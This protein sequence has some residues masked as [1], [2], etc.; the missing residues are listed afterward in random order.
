MTNNVYVALLNPAITLVFAAAFVVLWSYQRQRRY[1]LLFSL[2]Y[3]AASLGFLAQYAD[4]PGL[5][6][7]TRLISVGLFTASTLLIGSAVLLIYRRR[8]PFIGFAAVTAVG[9]A[10]FGWFLFVEPD[11]AWRVLITNFTLGGITLLVAAELRAL[12]DKSRLDWLLFWLALASGL[13]FFVRTALI[14]YI[15]GI[16]VPD[17]VHQSVYWTTALLSHAV[18]S[19]A[20]ALALIGRT[21]QDVITGLTEE[22]QT[23]PLS[24][25]LNRRGFGEHAGKLLAQAQR[26]GL[27]VSLVICDLDHF[28]A[29][30]DSFGHAC[31]DRVIVAAS[32]FFEKAASANYVVGRIGG[33]EFAIILSGANMPAARLFAEGARAAFSA[34][35]VDGL[36][37]A[38]R[39]T[40]SFGVAEL[41]ENE[42]VSALLARADA[43]LYRAKNEGRDRVCVARPS[44]TR[45]AA[46][47]AEAA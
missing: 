11:L 42:D 15:H 17:G 40:A 22:S 46:G 8:P 1:L 35:A 29:V 37:Q 9:A 3:V 33:E 24:G 32:S 38:H 13:N 25:L 27:P 31:G 34:I 21:V 26:R 4:A 30:N 16:D 36:P 10:G 12:P 2:G 5:Y 44:F 23:D 28:K 18:L 47:G 20:I 41:T 39:L 7:L 6:T 43:A 45:A 19:M 14:A